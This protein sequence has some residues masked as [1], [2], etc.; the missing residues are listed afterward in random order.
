MG[1]TAD[2][3]E[4]ESLLLLWQAVVERAIIDY[5]HAV[6]YDDEAAAS[7]IETEMEIMGYG[8]YLPEIKRREKLFCKAVTE[9]LRSVQRGH[10]KRMNC[11]ACHTRK[12]VYLYHGKDRASAFCKSCGCKYKIWE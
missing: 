4:V 3:S 8:S 11:P 7:T 2:R 5:R 10:Y 12:S 1:R 9:P 6:A